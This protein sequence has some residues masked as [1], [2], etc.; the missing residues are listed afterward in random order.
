MRTECFW[1]QFEWAH[2]S[3]FLVATENLGLKSL[4]GKSAGAVGKAVTK[5]TGAMGKV[6]TKGAGA[7]GKVVTKGTKQIGKT[8]TAI[9]DS[10]DKRALEDPH[11]LD[12]QGALLVSEHAPQTQIMS[13]QSLGFDAGVSA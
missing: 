9:A 11:N 7:V 2:F 13:G 1:S 6:A 5:S 8:L 10:P 12:K 3:F 4:V